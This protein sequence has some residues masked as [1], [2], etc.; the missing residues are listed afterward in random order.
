[1]LQRVARRRSRYEAFGS[2]RLSEMEAEV[3]KEEPK[4]LIGHREWPGDHELLG[5]AQASG[6]GLP[7]FLFFA[8]PS[9]PYAP[10]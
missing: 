2:L 3:K 5:R 1:M 9:A 8:Q 7:N 6:C 4:A 10:D